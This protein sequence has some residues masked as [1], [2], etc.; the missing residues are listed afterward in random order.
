MGAFDSSGG[1]N[2]EIDGLGISSLVSRL[3]WLL[4]TCSLPGG[5]ILFTGFRC[6]LTLTLRSYSSVVLIM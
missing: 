2:C 6:T 3:S 5:G 4:E 1:E